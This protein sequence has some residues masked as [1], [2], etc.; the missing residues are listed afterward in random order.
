[1]HEGK[2]KVVVKSCSGEPGVIKEEKLDV[3][4]LIVASLRCVTSI[5]EQAG[6][7]G[8]LENAQLGALCKFLSAAADAA[9]LEKAAK[10]AFALAKEG[11]YLRLGRELTENTTFTGTDGQVLKPTLGFIIFLT[12]CGNVTQIKRGMFDG[13]KPGPAQGT[14]PFRVL[15]DTAARFFVYAFLPLACGEAV[16]HLGLF[17]GRTVVQLE[18]WCHLKGDALTYAVTGK[19]RRRITEVDDETPKKRRRERKSIQ[20]VKPA[21]SA[22]VGAAAQVWLKSKSPTD[23]TLLD[24]NKVW[25]MNVKRSVA[26]EVAKAH[27]EQEPIQDLQEWVGR[28]ETFLCNTWFVKKL[29]PHLEEMRARGITYEDAKVHLVGGNYGYYLASD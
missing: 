2:A 11:A 20:D 21:L 16:D 19:E 29:K 14:K 13:T 1:M 9:E 24:R 18:D 4:L 6:I 23:G 15:I 26:K 3:D 8:N 17:G 12:G 25:D 28:V 10:K 7:G 5:L 22:V 27:G